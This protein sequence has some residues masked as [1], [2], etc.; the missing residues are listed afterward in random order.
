MNIQKM[1][2]LPMEKYER[3]KSC[4]NRGSEPKQQITLN[5]QEIVV[6]DP[7]QHDPNEGLLDK[8]TILQAVPKMY[9]G[10][11]KALLDYIQNGNDLS[12]NEKGEIVFMGKTVKNSH[13]ADLLKDAMR[14]YKNFDPIGKE[15]FYRGL[16]QSN[17][18][19][20]LLDN[21]Q[22][23]Q[24]LLKGKTVSEKSKSRDIKPYIDKRIKPSTHKRKSHNATL[25]KPKW[26]YI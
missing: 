15:E 18:P 4:Q 1:V 16:A 13:I 24:R 17:V 14:E 7:L 11:G 26:I 6:E 8:D 25:Q 22:N 2:L 5:N 9:K 20:L 21:V 10:K 3:L 19:V 23:R 12:W